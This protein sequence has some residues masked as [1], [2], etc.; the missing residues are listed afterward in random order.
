MS[1]TATEKV[2]RS[3]G[4]KRLVHVMFRPGMGMARTV[5]M[6]AGFVFKTTNRDVGNDHCAFLPLATGRG[7]LNLYNRKG[8]THFAQWSMEFH[9]VS[10]Q[11]SFETLMD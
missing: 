7:P 3:D 9:A 6:A 5:A 10:M 2:L 1:S 8:N 4:H 11:Q